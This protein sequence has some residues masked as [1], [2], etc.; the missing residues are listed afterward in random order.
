MR[1]LSERQYCILDWRTPEPRMLI[2]DLGRRI[3]ET[4]A[5][6]TKILCNLSYNTPQL[7]YYAQR[8]LLYGVTR[9]PEGAAKVGGVFWMDT[10]EGNKLVAELPRGWEQFVDFGGVRFCL[11]KRE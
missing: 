2:V 6:D 9:P 7:E 1:L 8:Q 4:F 11:W 10:A 3:G 5:P